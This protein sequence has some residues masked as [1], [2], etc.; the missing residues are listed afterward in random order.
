MFPGLYYGDHYTFDASLGYKTGTDPAN[1][2]L[3]NLNFQFAINNLFN[4]RPPFAY[5]FGSGRGTAA[6]NAIDPRQRYLPS[7][8]TP[9]SSAILSVVDANPKSDRLITVFAE[10]PISRFRLRVC[11]RSRHC[12]CLSWK[13]AAVIVAARNLMFGANPLLA[14]AI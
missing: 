7:T 14:K 12:L 11:P 10:K 2:Y 8:S 6:V 4:R 1:E 5:L 9:T 13:A 3:Q